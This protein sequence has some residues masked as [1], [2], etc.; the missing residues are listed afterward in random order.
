MGK[1]KANELLYLGEKM[2]AK[3]ALE[4]HFVSKVFPNK[5]EALKY[6]KEKA[7]ILKN[8]DFKSL[9]ACKKLIVEEER[10]I[11]KQVNERELENLVERWASESLIPTLAKSF[12]AKKGKSKL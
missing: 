2:T 3:D 4:N 11:L 10:K 1:S 9:M 12:F 5:I 6:A 7:D 8:Y